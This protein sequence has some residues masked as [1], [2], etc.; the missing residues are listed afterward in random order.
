MNILIVTN[1]ERHTLNTICDC[2]LKMPRNVKWKILGNSYSHQELIS[3]FG[4]DRFIDIP[5]PD[6]SEHLQEDHKPFDFLNNISEKH[7]IVPTDFQS[8]KFLSKNRKSFNGHIVCPLMEIP[9]LNYLDDKLNMKKIADECRVLS[10]N[11]YFFSQLEKL[12]S[13]HRL[14]IK[15]NFGSGSKGVFISQNKQQA[16][17]YYEQL[18]PEKKPKHVIQDYIDG[19]DFY[20]YGICHN[21]KILVSSIIKP[22][23]SK[24]LG[25][26]FVDNP[27]VDENA[28]KIIAHYKYSGPISIDYRIDKKS[29]EVYLIEINP[30]NGNNAYLFNVANTNWLFEL[31]KI[32]ENPNIYPNTHK[33]I[34]NKW[35]C[36]RK[37]G[38]L[39]F[40]YKLKIYKIKAR[41]K[42]W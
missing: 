30:R 12:Q 27:S 6:L 42:T 3:L 4:K 39:F 40:V 1:S 37:I 2:I 35:I 15:P 34:T 38:W 9:L 33:I 41:L 14:A 21:G 7:I 31:A 20:Y 25:T 36:F 11:E 22:G 8:L 29:K 10:P 19:E 17:D 24:H 16:I 32:S 18:T 13:S 5:I 28:K 26:Y 23:L